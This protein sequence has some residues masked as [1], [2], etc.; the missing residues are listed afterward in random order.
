MDQFA[1]VYDGYSV[2][3]CYT[4]VVSKNEAFIVGEMTQGS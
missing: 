3:C 4:A 2:L 1:Q